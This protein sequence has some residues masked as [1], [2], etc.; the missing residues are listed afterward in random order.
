MTHLQKFQS[1]LSEKAEAALITS[2]QN[3]FYLS[4]FEFSDGYVL[5]FPDRAYLLTDFRYEEAARANAAEGIEVLSPAIGVLKKTAEL[6]REHH[7]RTLLV[8]ML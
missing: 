5:V 6:L 1:K 7:V 3:R 2:P 4:D 8:R